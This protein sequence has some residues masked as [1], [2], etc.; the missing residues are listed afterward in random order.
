LK[1]KGWIGSVS[2]SMPVDARGQPIPWYTY[3]AIDFL[4]ER[5]KR[6]M[7]V[8]EYGS[9]NSTLWWSDRV[10]NV[11][12]CEHDKTWYGVMRDRVPANVEYCLVEL[13]PDGQYAT[14]VARQAEPFD[15]IVIDGRER[16]N[17]AKAAL[18]ALKDDGVVVW[19]NSDRPEYEA[20]FR[21]LV[22]KR[23]RRIDF[24][25]MGPINTYGW[26]T[27]LFYRSRNCFDI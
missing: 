4:A 22:D 16:V 24:W 6:S 2:A 26:C 3:C 10:R 19:D 15:V 14:A 9:G 27:S 8:F 20:G 7:R 11:V 18:G 12:S 5:A 21:L 13:R 23:F 17:C 25:G 1:D